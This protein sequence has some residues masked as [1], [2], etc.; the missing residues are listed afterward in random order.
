MDAVLKS[1]LWVAAAPNLQGLNDLPKSL[2]FQ[3]LPFAVKPLLMQ[4]QKEQEED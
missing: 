1:S 3:S 2:P 4:G